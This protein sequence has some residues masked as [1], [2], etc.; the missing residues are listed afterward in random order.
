MTLKDFKKSDVYKLADTVCF[1]NGCGQE[2]EASKKLSFAN[3]I[4]HYQDGGYLE[5]E[6][7]IVS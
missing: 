5:I 3:V 6:L 4:N 1:I 2:I 7:D